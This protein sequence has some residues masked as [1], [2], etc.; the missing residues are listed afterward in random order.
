[1]TASEPTSPDLTAADLTLRPARPDEVADLSRVFVAAR[2]AAAPDLPL[3]VHGEEE[4]RAH[5]AAAVSAPDREVWVADAG[6]GVAGFLVLTRT[7]LDDL[8]VDPAH[9]RR[10]VGSALLDLARAQRPQGFGLWVFATNRPARAFYAHH[11]LVELETTDGSA[12]EEGAPDVRVVWPGERPLSHL[13]AAIDEVDDQLAELL[14]RRAALTAAVQ[15]HK[16]AA[17]GA[18]GHRGRD[19]GREA[20]IVERMCR[21]APGLEPERLARVMDVV[22][23]ESL[24]AWEQRAGAAPSR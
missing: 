21:H 6:E 24:E 12:T 18:G 8:Y 7:W 17:G 10:G 13:R 3:P 20:E 9:Q 14:A 2:R 15:D 23:G 5:L 19:A 22:I 1:M 4:V 16:D 11:G